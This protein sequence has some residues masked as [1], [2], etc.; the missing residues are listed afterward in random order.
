MTRNVYRNRHYNTPGHAHELTFSCYRRIPFF[1][2]SLAC[3]LFLEELQSGRV[4]H[5]F[6]IWAY[7]IMPNHIHLLIK[8]GQNEYSIATIT[9]SIKGRFAKK[10]LKRLSDLEEKSV[11]EKCT[12]IEKGQRKHRI[13]QRGGGFDRNMWNPKAIHDAIRYIEA[14]PVRARLI[15]TP[16][17]WKW[18]SSWA[19]R[20]GCGVV[21]D[22]FT[23]PVELPDPQ[24][25]K[26]KML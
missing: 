24:K 10:Y 26:M 11:L 5:D 3:E 21:P 4:E 12:V 25:I 2:K 22:T 14:N 23:L 19:R 20:N 17:E 6:L 15:V 16:V 8:P 13:W 1:S 7:V 9:K 18:S